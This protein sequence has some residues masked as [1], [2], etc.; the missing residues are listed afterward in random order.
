MNYRDSLPDGC[1]PIEAE[2]IEITRDVFRLVRQTPPTIGDFQSQRTEKPHNT[3]RVSEC[4]ACG[5]SVFANRQ[6]CIKAKKLTA[7]RNRLSCRIQLAAGAGCIQQ[8]GHPSHHT[9]WPSRDF[10]ILSHCMVEAP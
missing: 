4:Q 7:L 6:D 10:D 2:Q 1:P 9:W 3:F 8:T 5:L